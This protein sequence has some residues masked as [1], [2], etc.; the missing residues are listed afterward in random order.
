ME[1]LDV[2]DMNG[3]FI[4]SYFT[5]DKGCAHENREHTL[6]YLLSGELEISDHGRKTVLRQGDCAYMRRDNLMYLQKRV[7]NDVP[8]HSIVLK[9]SPKFLKEFYR[10]LNRR[11]IPFT[12]AK[13]E[14]KSLRVLPRDR[15]DIKS[16]F[17]SLVPFFESGQQPSADLQRLKMTEGLYVL[18]N[19]DANLYASLF[20][21]VEPWK[22]D[23]LEYLNENY[24]EDL[25]ME[26]IA[27]N[28]GRSLA[29]FKRDFTKYSSLTPQ[30]W[31]IRKRLEVAHQMLS[32]GNTRV[33]DVCYD[34][35]FKNPSHFSRIYKEVY[36]SAPSMG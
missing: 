11:D 3:A 34:V 25:S 16:L 22:I 2:L 31:I 28:T 23:I 20:D 29:T 10:S 21:F 24:A 36:G 19:T 12:D 1:K 4:A 27:K 8:Y 15:A 9:F 13:R 35:G 17:E 18:L 33:V 30:K 5:D 26:D 14:K 32:L 7:K 6:I